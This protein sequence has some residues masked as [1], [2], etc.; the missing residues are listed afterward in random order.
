MFKKIIPLVLAACFLTACDEQ[1]VKKVLKEN[2]EI[3]AEV[4][5]ENPKL[6]MEAL[7]KASLKMREEQ[8]KTA[9]KE[10]EQQM[11]EEFKN[12]RKPKLDEKR[13][14]FGKASAPITIVEYSD[15]QCYYC[16]KA[17]NEAVKQV[18]DKYKGKVRVLYKHLPFQQHAEIAAKYYEAVAKL[19]KSK[20]KP[21][22]D[23]VFAKQ[24][25]LRG[26]GE[27]LLESVV[28]DIGLD[29]K[30]V[31]KELS[32]VA[33]VVQEDKA[34]ALKFGFR[35]TPAFLV[36]GVTLNGAQPF[37][38]FQWVINRHLKEM[39]HLKDVE[40]GKSKEKKEAS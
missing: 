14:F 25:E 34:E 7:N 30:K 38:R 20:A 17:N 28:K 18:L 24:V 35:G 36:N 13:V 26:K 4:I 3:L 19:D 16:Q 9:E 40:K 2:P 23:K 10:R 12:P 11:E 15:F 5:E 29:V 8:L 33:D 21:F 31:K 32:N 1:Q 37:S 39:G 6:I 22:H 27:K